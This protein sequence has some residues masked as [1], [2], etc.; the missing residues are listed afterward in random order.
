MPAGY[1]ADKWGKTR[2]VRLGFLLCALGLWGIPILHHLH[3]GMT[4]FMV[5]AGVLG[6]GFV[7]AFPAWLA[8]LTELGGEKQRG[9][10][11]A[12][13]STAQG[14]GALAGAVIGT[15]TLRVRRPHRAVRRRLVFWSRWARCWP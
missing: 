4:G 14:V 7:L 6:A 3:T 13:V 10:V 15:Q 1:L 5:S 12:A 2:C 9:T 11:F 8:L